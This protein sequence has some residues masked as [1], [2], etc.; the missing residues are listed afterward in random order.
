M[1]F[2]GSVSKNGEIIIECHILAKNLR[3]KLKVSKNIKMR[4]KMQLQ[5]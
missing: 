2:A 3:K 5:S 1:S 4:G